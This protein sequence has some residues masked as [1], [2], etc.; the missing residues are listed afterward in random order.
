MDPA[1]EILQNTKMT[2]LHNRTGRADRYGNT[3]KDL[4]MLEATAR[5]PRVELFSRDAEGRLD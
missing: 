3:V 4:A 2:A 5:H 1:A